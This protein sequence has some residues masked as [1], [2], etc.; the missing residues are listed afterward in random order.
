MFSTRVT[1]LFLQ[2]QRLGQDHAA[3]AG[4]RGAEPERVDVVL[5]DAG[6]LEGVLRGV[7]QQVVGALVPGLDE[8]RAAHADDGDAVL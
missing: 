1:G 6:R 8:G 7:D 4:L 3:H 5:G 2:L